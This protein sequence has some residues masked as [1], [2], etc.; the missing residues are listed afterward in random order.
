MP[1]GGIVEDQQNE[2]MTSDLM[3]QAKLSTSSIL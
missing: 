1:L 2:G 3:V